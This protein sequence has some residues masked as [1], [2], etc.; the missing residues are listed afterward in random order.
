MK[1]KN[2][3]CPPDRILIS[4]AS[5]MPNA[6][7]SRAK[8]P[9]ATRWEDDDLDVV[10]VDP[11]EVGVAELGTG[12]PVATAPKPPVTGPLSEICKSLRED[13]ER[14]RSPRKQGSNARVFRSNQEP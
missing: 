7:A 14:P 12:V 13:D 5:V 10:E 11:E 2:A 4:H 8:K 9:F 6:A 1:E 3:A